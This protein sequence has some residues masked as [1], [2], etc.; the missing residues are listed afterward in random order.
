MWRCSLLSLQLYP[1]VEDQIT[2]QQLLTQA[3]Q[4]ERFRQMESR[5][6][7]SLFDYAAVPQLRPAN[8]NHA[9]R[10]VLAP[11]ECPQ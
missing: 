4:I 11:A 3:Q 5:H 1:I 10:C 7:P 2:A 9:A 6:I 8:S